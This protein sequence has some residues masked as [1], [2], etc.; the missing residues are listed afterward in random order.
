VWEAAAAAR[1]DFI[2]ELPHGLYTIVGD[3]GT[4]L[5]GGQRQRVALA[6]AFLKDAPLLL[7]DEA[8]SSLDKQCEQ[9]IR[10]ALERLMRGRTVIAITHRLSTIE[11]FD[12][13]L[14][15]QCGDLMQDGSPS[16]LANRAGPY[17]DL[18]RAGKRL[19]RTDTLHAA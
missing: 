8:T 13:I 4:R 5:S 2:A 10:E 12:R 9:A 18:L 17:R 19:S 6:R 14:L 3:R 15:I 11:R 16:E 7:L 1:C